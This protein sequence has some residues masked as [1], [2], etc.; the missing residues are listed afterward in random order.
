MFSQIT[1]VGFFEKINFLIFRS[2]KK[3]IFLNLMGPKR[4][5]GC[6]QTFFGLFDHGFVGVILLVIVDLSSGFGAFFGKID[7]ENLL[8]SRNTS[9]VTPPKPSSKRPKKVWWQQK[10]FWG[11]TNCEKLIFWAPENEKIDFLKKPDFYD[12]AEHW[13]FPQWP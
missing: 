2:P 1:E 4:F 13:G 12:L 9:S 10:S 7:Y 11:P 8:R 3:S 5:F 6:H